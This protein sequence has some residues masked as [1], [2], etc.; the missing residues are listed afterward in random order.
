MNL[1]NRKL[2]EQIIRIKVAPEEEMDNDM[3]Q[4]GAESGDSMEVLSQI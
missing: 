4:E 1:R 2:P 3:S